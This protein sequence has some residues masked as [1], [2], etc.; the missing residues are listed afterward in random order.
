M[1]S[2][3]GQ[4]MCPWFIYPSFFGNCINNVSG[5][6]CR[7]PN[8]KKGMGRTRINKEGSQL[9]NLELFQQK[10]F[11]ASATSTILR[12]NDMG[13]H[14][15]SPLHLAMTTLN[16]VTQGIFYWHFVLESV[17]TKVKSFRA[18]FK[19]YCEKYCSTV[20][21][22]IHSTFANQNSKTF[23]LG[24]VHCTKVAKQSMRRINA[25]SK[26]WYLVRSWFCKI[27]YKT[28]IFY[29]TFQYE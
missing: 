15:V 20:L 4:C 27:L 8:H 13:A 17:L 19:L 12:L 5:M 7:G 29:F 2:W 28:H 25:S 14:T 11:N 23:Q 6:S 9:W 26:T 18:L 22:T 16:S 24:R 10:N 21:Y 3:K 1:A